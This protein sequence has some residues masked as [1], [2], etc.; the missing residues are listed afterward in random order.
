MDHGDDFGV[1]IGQEFAATD[2]RSEEDWAQIARYVRG[3]A[4]KLARPEL[5]LCLPGEPQ[6]CG[7][8]ARQ[9]AL[10]WAAAV[11]ARAH[12]LIETTAP[13]SAHGTNAAGPLYQ[14]YLAELR[15]VDTA[16]AKG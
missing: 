14:H 2:Q 3:A 15:V 6:E 9:H 13:T 4:N 16:T 5:P 12:R 11:K 1:W 10:V 7:R 8:T